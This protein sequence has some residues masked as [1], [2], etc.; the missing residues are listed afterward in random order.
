MN[1][2]MHG[3]ATGNTTGSKSELLRNHFA[4]DEILRVAGAGDALCARIGERTGYDALWASGLGISAAHAVPDAGILTMTELLHAAATMDKATSL[5]VIADCDTGFG[6]VNVVRHMVASYQHAGIAAICIEDKAFP[7]RNSFRPGQQLADPHEFGAK[8]KA[9]K[10]AQTSESFMV[11]A[12]LESFI[13]GAGLEDA[14]RRALCYVECGADAILVHSKSRQADEVLGF[15][16]R[17][18]DEAW[19]TPLV[20][21]PTTYATVTEKELTDAGYSAVIYAN[22]ALRAAM[23]AITDTLSRIRKHGTSAS[24]EDQI[25]PVQDLLKLIGMDEI[26]RFDG[27]F[28]EEVESL[29]ETARAPDPRT[30]ISSFSSESAEHGGGV[31][32]NGDAPREAEPTAPLHAAVNGEARAPAPVGGNR[33]G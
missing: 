12:R 6:D 1:Q 24:T 10:E 9:A 18:N 2:A 33:G 3:N 26:E 5:P 14:L 31:G 16:D 17:W 23:R 8:V 25:A 28:T 15:A 7:K 27:W 20:C 29:R 22:Q 21:V 19:P 11:I 30:V 32:L 13:A 4:R